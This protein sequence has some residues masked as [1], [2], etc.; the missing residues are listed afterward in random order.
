MKT[1]T[2]EEV[3]QN[4]RNELLK[5]V[6]DDHCLCEVAAQKHIYCGGFGQ[7]TNSQ[8][9]DRYR[10]L[11]KQKAITSRHELE[12]RANRWQLQRQYALSKALP[13]DVRSEERRVGK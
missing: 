2:R 7:F 6:D 12:A 10:W 5:L 1:L 13:C 8:L 4:I 3:I 11:V 9:F